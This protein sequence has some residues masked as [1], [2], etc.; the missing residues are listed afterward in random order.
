MSCNV[1]LFYFSGTGTTKLITE[2]IGKRFEDEKHKIKIFAIE[3]VLHNH[4]QNNINDFDI[5]GLG[6]PVHAFNAP[7]NFYKF[8][9]LIPKVTNKKLFLFKTAGSPFIN[10]GT[11]KE[12]KQLLIKKGFDVVYEE[13]FIL[14]SNCITKLPD[15]L[16]IKLYEAIKIQIDNMVLNIKNN[17]KQI[18]EEKFLITIVS[19]IASTFESIGTKFLRYNFKVNSDC[20]KC[21]KCINECPQKNITLDNENFVFDWHCIACLRCV[22]NCPTNSIKINL[23]NKFIFESFNIKKSLLNKNNNNDDNKKYDLR[24]IKHI[25]KINS[26]KNN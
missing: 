2:D 11:T 22:Y 21:K 1:G 16:I 15:S 17:Q 9:N 26:K 5:I 19:I 6:F 8:L 18:F 14:A 3:D 4:N 10:G 25:D 13:L 20:I 23:L 24:Y 7:R 12:I